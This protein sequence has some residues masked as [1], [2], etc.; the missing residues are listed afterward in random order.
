MAMKHKN[1]KYHGVII[2]IS[3][4][5]QILNVADVSL[6]G[7]SNFFYNDF[8]PIFIVMNIKYQN[9]SLSSRLLNGKR[10]YLCYDFIWRSTKRR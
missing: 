2:V 4:R 10:N 1:K 3:M 7:I 8:V 9:G 6:L 5:Y